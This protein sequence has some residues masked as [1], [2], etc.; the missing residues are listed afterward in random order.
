VDPGVDAVL[1]E[2]ADIICRAP[3][4]ASGDCHVEGFV[5]RRGRILVDAEDVYPGV[6]TLRGNRVGIPPDGNGQAALMV[7]LRTGRPGPEWVIEVARNVLSST[8]ASG[9]VGISI[10]NTFSGSPMQ[11]DV[12]DNLVESTHPQGVR[13]GILVAHAAGSALR[14]VRNIVRGPTDTDFSSSLLSVSVNSGSSP[15]VR[16]ADNW[17]HAAPNVM[18]KGGLMGRTRTPP[19]LLSEPAGPLARGARPAGGRVR[20]QHPLQGLHASTGEAGRLSCWAGQQAQ[21]PV[22]RGERRTGY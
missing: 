9:A 19:Q 22:R 14:L 2:G 7:E 10:S 5:L 18:V 13:Q 6:V 1:A 4:G 8:A 11:V 17:L 15:Q 12:R 21:N 3:A 20:H 16:I